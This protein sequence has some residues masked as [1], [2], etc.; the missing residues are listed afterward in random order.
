[1]AAQPAPDKMNVAI[2]NFH[3]LFICTGLAEAFR[4]VLSVILRPVLVYQPVH[5][6][7]ATGHRPEY[8]SGGQAVRLRAV[9]NIGHPHD[10]VKMLP[11]GGNLAQNGLFV[12]DNSMPVR[13]TTGTHGGMAWIGD[14]GIN[15]P[16]APYYRRLFPNGSKGGEL[17]EGGQV[18]IHHRIL[19]DNHGKFCFL[20]Y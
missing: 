13:I 3:R 20:H 1:M 5:M 2:Y 15:G 12:V 14:G 18:F 8:R 6:R 11:L 9:K 10:A 19:T 4:L 7:M 17:P 16:V